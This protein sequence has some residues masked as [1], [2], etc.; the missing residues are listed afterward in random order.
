MSA[1]KLPE[2]TKLLAENRRA[3]HKYTIEDRVEVGMVLLGS[4]VK[5]I[6]AGR[7]ELVDAYA[8][9]QDGN[10]VLLNSY[11]A[12]WPYAN[13]EKHEE[14]RTRRLLAHRMEIDKLNT[15]VTRQGYTVIPLLAYLKGGRIKL[16]VGLAKGKDVGDR[17]QEIKKR[18]SDREARAEL[19]RRR[20]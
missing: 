8:I 15:K 19:K 1:P 2:G 14:R 12:P 20:G 17:R 5:S 9:V 7:F 18:D 16:E 10:L 6:R 4:E 11:V 3:L 13:V